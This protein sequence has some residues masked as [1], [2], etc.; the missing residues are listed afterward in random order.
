MQK[1]GKKYYSE[2]NIFRALIIIWVVIGHC[3]DTAQ[4]IAVSAFAHSYAYTFHMPAFFIISGFLFAPK[5]L[6]AA[7]PADKGQLILN[8]LKRLIVPYLFL[9]MV[10]YILKF[11]FEKYANNELPKGMDIAKCIFLGVNNPNGG[12]WFLYAL[13]VLSVLAVLIRFIPTKFSVIVFAGLKILTFFVDIDIPVINYICLYGIYFFG[14]ILMVNCYDKISQKLNTLVC[15]KKGFV[16]LSAIVLIMLTVSFII[17]YFY[18]KI[19]KNE[20]ISTLIC[21]YNII[22]WYLLSLPICKI[23]LLKNALS[24]IGNY[25]M[26]IYMIGYYVQIVIRVVLGTMLGLPFIIYSTLMFVMGLLVP[27]PVSKYIVRKVRLFRI[28]ILGDFSKNK[29]S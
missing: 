16:T 20:F 5:I 26:D 29:E 2:L 6:S 23:K 10:S 14:G 28:L 4:G 12:L 11:F 27:I 18:F 9:T 17:S 22:V 1:N 19:E 24:A 15:N 3:A 7:A 21:I 8:R 13:F 25:G